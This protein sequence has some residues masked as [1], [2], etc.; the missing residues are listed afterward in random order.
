MGG[1]TDI[2]FLQ[3]PAIPVHSQYVFELKY[4]K[5]QDIA[6]LPL[7]QK[8]AK[9]QLAAYLETEPELGTQPNL[10]AWTIVVVKDEIKLEQVR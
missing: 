10:R 8:E 3:R 2:Q 5:K 6:Q 4:L 7:V 9:K 1:Y